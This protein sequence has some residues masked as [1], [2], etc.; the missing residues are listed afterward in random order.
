MEFGQ[1]VFNQEREKFMRWLK[2]PNISLGG[3]R[4]E[5]L[6]DSVTGMQEVRNCLNRIE[7]GNLA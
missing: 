5:D 1:E 2:K 4:P 3:N 7:F 6:F